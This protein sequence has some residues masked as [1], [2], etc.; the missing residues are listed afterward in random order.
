MENTVLSATRDNT[1]IDILMESV[2]QTLHNM[3]LTMLSEQKSFDRKTGIIT[4][5]SQIPLQMFMY[6]CLN[7]KPYSILTLTNIRT[8]HDTILS[9]DGYFEVAQTFSVYFHSK[10][11]MTT[12]L[13]YDDLVNKTIEMLMQYTTP[14]NIDYVMLPEVIRSQL[15]Y[16]DIQRD[17]VIIWKNIITGNKWMLPL[18]LLAVFTPMKYI[19]T[20]L[21]RH[22]QNNIEDEMLE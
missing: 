22:N 16:A 4:Q 8:F 15:N 7:I 2:E 14:S 6:C 10:L 21:K 13:D 20:W 12:N 3:S 18:I 9:T 19:D 17:D 1:I 11:M 5:P